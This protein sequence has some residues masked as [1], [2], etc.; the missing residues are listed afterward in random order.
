MEHNFTEIPIDLMTEI[1]PDQDILKGTET[2]SQKAFDGLNQQSKQTPFPDDFNPVNYAGQGQGQQL[3]AGNLITPEMAVNFMDIILPGLLVMIIKKT[4]DKTVSKRSFNLTATEKE[5][6]KPVLHNY[7]NSIN[8]RV[9]N[10]GNALILT[11]AMIYG[12]KAVEVINETPQGKFNNSAPPSGIGKPTQT[13]GTTKQDGRGR[14]KGST[15][16]KN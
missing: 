4:M 13:T 12:I 5:T 15:K 6:I 3:N 2:D 10:P 1:T 7:L 14:P 16:K 9:E 8:F 11:V